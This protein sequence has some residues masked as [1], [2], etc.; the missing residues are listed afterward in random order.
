MAEVEQLEVNSPAHQRNA[1]RISR[2]EQELQELMKQ[3]GMAKEDETPE[4]EQ[5]TEAEPR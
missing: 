1:A 3:A 4:E 2:D 5:T